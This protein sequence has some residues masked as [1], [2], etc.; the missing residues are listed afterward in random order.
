MQTKKKIGAALVLLALA[1]VP[2]AVFWFHVPAIA[3]V[4]TLLAVGPI[5]LGTVVVTYQ[6]TEVNSAGGPAPGGGYTG[7][8]IAPTATQMVGINSL[9]ALITYAD[10]DTVITINHNMQITALGLSALQPYIRWY[11]QSLA[12]ST[13]TYPVLSFALTSGNV[14][15]INKVSNTGT[16]GTLVVQISRG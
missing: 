4:I 1:I 15:T 7:G 10:T 14:V 6:T 13:N 11:F 12:A 2:A 8:T 16:A 5:G 9:V 3:T